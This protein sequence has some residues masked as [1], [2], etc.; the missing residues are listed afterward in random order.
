M[1][2]SSVAQPVTV[3]GRDRHWRPRWLITTPLTAPLQSRA[4]N[5]PLKRPGRVAVGTRRS[6]MNGG[7][8]RAALGQPDLPAAHDG[9]RRAV[10]RRTDGCGRQE[11]GPAEGRRRRLPCL[12]GPGK[13]SCSVVAVSAISDNRRC[14]IER[15]KGQQVS[16]LVVGPQ[17]GGVRCR[18]SL[19]AAN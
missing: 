2:Q 17:P 13:T 14:I 18:P 6:V 4:K 19:S 12:A 5:A 8:Q 15:T 16:R 3:M 1:H 10:G 7:G 9:P 11:R